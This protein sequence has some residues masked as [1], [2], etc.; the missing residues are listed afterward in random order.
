MYHCMRG[1]NDDDDDLHNVMCTT[2]G[3]GRVPC[4][5]GAGWFAACTTG[6]WIKNAMGAPA[7]N[8][9]RT[10]TPKK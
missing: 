1:I 6:Q 10:L 2:V 9:C 8:T 7:T 5:A 3:L 4:E